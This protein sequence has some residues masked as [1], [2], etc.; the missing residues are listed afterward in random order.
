MIPLVAGLLKFGFSTLAGALAGKGQEIIQE[1]LGVNIG[2]MLGTEQG[3]IELKKLEMQ[4]EEFLLTAAQA[5]EVR[6]LEYFKEEVEDKGS[7]R[8]R[9]SEFIKSGVVNWRANLMF[10]LAC[11]MVA[12]LVWIVWKDDSLNEYVKGIFTL[13]LGR[14]LGY[15]DNIYNFEFG[16]T[17]SSRTK[18]ATIDRLSGGQ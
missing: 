8:L 13:V 18:D 7:A 14:F 11:A 17:R 10:F 2:D 9:D 4:H 5:S 3:R 6:D 16:T 1:K 15:L 12:W